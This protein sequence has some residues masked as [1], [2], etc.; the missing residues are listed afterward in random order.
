MKRQ[1]IL[2][3]VG[4]VLGLIASAA[5]RAEDAARPLTDMVPEGALLYAG[6]PGM[7]TLRETMDDTQLAKILREPEIVRFREAWGSKIWPAIEENLRNEMGRDGE[8]ILEEV[9]EIVQASW[10]RPMAFSLINVG[11][12]E[13]GPQVDAALIIRAGEDAEELVEAAE[14]LAA[15]GGLSLADAEKVEVKGAT[16]KRMTLLDPPI[17]LHWGVVG[18]DFVLVVGPKMIELLNGAADARGLG[19]SKPFRAAMEATGGSNVVPVWYVDLA[20]AV[21]TIETFQPLFEALEIPVVGEERGVQAIL[22]ELGIGKA[23]WIANAV[24]STAGGFKSTTVFRVPDLDTSEG[25]LYGQAPL[26]DADLKRIPRDVTWGSAANWDVAGFYRTIMDVIAAVQ[27]GVKNEIEG[28]IAEVEERLGFE[29]EKD[30][31]GAFGDTWILYDAPASGGLWFTGVTLVAELKPD[32]Q[33]DRVLS[34]LTETIAEE[35]EG[36][37]VELSILRETHRGQ[38]IHILNVAGVPMPFAPAW[39]V[40]KGQWIAGLYPQMVRLA[41]DHMMKEGSPSLLDNEDF[42]RGRRQMPDRPCA[43]SYMDTR[44]GLRTLYMVGLPLA[45]VAFAMLQGQ[46]VPIDA[47]MIPSLSS[48]ER[49]LFGNVSATAVTKDGTI[50]VSYGAVPASMASIGQV[51]VLTPMLM[52]ITLPSLARARELSK[53]SVSAAN[54][55]A[56]AI[57]CFTYANENEGKFPPDLDTL[58]REGAIARQTLISPLDK[59]HVASSYVYISGQKDSMDPRNIV[60]YEYP[61]NYDYEGTNAAFLDGHVEYMSMPEFERRLQ[62]T[63]ERLDRKLEIEE[64]GA[65]PQSARGVRGNARTQVATMMVK[66]GGPLATSLELFRL[67]VGRYPN[68]LKELYEKPEDEEAAGKWAGPYIKD[69]ESL[70]DPWG[71]TYQYTGGDEEP[72]FNSGRYDLWSMGPDGESN[73]DDDIG[74]WTRE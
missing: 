11:M 45:Q 16:L 50:S 57:G 48:I 42:Q 12:G 5:A 69:A 52:G 3:G 9:L 51:S 36:G 29:I 27:P 65:G 47:T 68:E 8:Q 31:V 72:E 4:M 55:R 34:R 43:I 23:E 60:A 28:A 19:Q 61:E 35:V 53:R 56:V 7:D 66:S 38:E 1:R 6:W 62:E 37:N 22:D 18:P 67:Q 58:V 74:N 71:N 46:G 64:R 70:E 17:T 30:L 40:Y 33:I 14:S 20:G 2:S 54:L 13:D 49:H 25:S 32:Q 21:K 73:T 15:Y 59:E 44:A 41:L 24:T 26:E 63:G 10:H 39:T